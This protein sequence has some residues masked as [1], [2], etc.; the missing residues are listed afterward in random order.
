M[1]S[2][3]MQENIKN[4]ATD[5]KNILYVF[6]MSDKC[7]FHLQKADKCLLQKCLTS[8]LGK[9][10]EILVPLSDLSHFF[11]APKSFWSFIRFYLR[12]ETNLNRPDLLE[13]YAA[14]LNFLM[15]VCRR[16]QHWLSVFRKDWMHNQIAA[17]SALDDHWCAAY[18]ESWSESERRCRPS[19]E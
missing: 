7:L 18:E 6:K 4:I 16:K 8:I 14:H 17:S 3:I 13:P 12:L 5:V 2:Q 9:E 11:G 19:R 1:P 10:R 15:A